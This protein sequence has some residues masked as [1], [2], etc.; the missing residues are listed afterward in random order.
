MK[1][2]DPSPKL[3]YSSKLSLELSDYKF[4][5]FSVIDIFYVLKIGA[6]N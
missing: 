3:S 4:I 6:L 2:T 5:E 1:Y